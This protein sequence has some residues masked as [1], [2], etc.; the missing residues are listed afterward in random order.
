[1]ARISASE[2]DG[3]GQWIVAAGV[4]DQA[5]VAGQGGFD[6]HFFDHDA[7]VVEGGQLGRQRADVHRMETGLVD[8]HRH[9]DANVVGQVGDQLGVGHVAVE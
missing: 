6:G 1:M 2:S 5:R 8:K 7:E 3:G 9:L 4:V